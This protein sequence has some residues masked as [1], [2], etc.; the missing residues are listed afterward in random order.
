MLNWVFDLKYVSKI[1][2]HHPTLTMG[3]IKI[4]II[5]PYS[6]KTLVPKAIYLHLIV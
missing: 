5:T 3:C 1:N 6:T 2:H 4:K